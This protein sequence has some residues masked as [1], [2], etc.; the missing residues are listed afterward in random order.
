M[1]RLSQFWDAEMKNNEKFQRV[2][3]LEEMHESGLTTVGLSDA[4][5]VVEEIWAATSQICRRLDALI[6]SPPP[7][8]SVLEQLSD[9][10]RSFLERNVEEVVVKTKEKE[11]A[12]G[13]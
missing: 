6:A 12:H 7:E 5:K 8:Y 4:D 1:R 11:T 9:E 10:E 2:M 3:T 13:S